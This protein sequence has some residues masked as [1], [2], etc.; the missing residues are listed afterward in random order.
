[1][2]HLYPIYVDIVMPV[3][4]SASNIINPLLHFV[5]PAVRFISSKNLRFSASGGPL[6]GLPEPHSELVFEFRSGVREDPRGV[7]LMPKTEVSELIKRTAGL[8]KWSKGLMILDAD[9]PTG[10]T[11]S[12]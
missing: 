1:M 4:A 2:S 3:S 10:I 6:G 11:M 9:A 8:T 7:P 12:T 5:K